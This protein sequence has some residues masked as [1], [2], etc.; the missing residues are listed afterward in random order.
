[1]NNDENPLLKEWTTAYGIPPFSDIEAPQFRQAFDEALKQDRTD[2]DRIAE[3]TD[4]PTFENTIDRLQLSGQALTKVASVFFNLTS[5]DTNPALQEIEREI[6]PRLASHRTKTYLNA[7]LFARIEKLR[8]KRDQLSLTDEQLK[9]LERIHTD[10]VRAGAKL[11]AAERE[12]MSE[13]EERLAQLS[14][15]F[16]QNVLAEEAG[17]ELRLKNDD[18]LAGLPDFLRNAAAQTA[19]ERGYDNEFV[20]TLS[21]SSIEPF[22]TFSERR[23]LREAAYQAWKGRGAAGGET[24][25]RELIDEIIE[26]RTEKANLLGFANFADY[27]LSDQMAKTPKAVHKLLNDVWAPARDRAA[28]EAEMLAAAAQNEGNNA[29]LAPWDWWHY[30]EK[31]RREKH[32]VDETEVKPYL[33]LANVRNAA[34]YVA[35]RLFGLKFKPVADVTLHHPDALAFDV[36]DQNGNHVGLFVGDYYA[37]PSKRGGAWMSAFRSQ[38]KLGE[39]IRPIIINVMNFVKAGPGE[40]DLLT[41]DDARTLF[42]E[43]GHALHGL[44][45]NVTYPRVACTNVPSDFV[46]LPSQLYEHWFLQPEILQ[47]FAVHYKTGKPMPE[48]LIQRILDARNFNQGFALVEFLAS[49]I[50]DMDL[51]ASAEGQSVNATEVEQKTLKRIDMPSAIE[52]RHKAT[53]FAHL[54]Q[55]SG[56]AAGYYSYLWSEVL[57]ADAFEAFEETGNVFDGATAKRLAENIYTVGGSRDVGETYRAFRGRDARVEALLEKRGLA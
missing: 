54:F 37:R 32:N 40:A 7:P 51:H 13:I 47:R 41:L 35:E 43:F 3:Q 27:R 53:H 52:P 16:G 24:D 45:S 15:T 14:T 2:I 28:S 23:D 39:D 48:D 50:T 31:V 18:D 21:R 29:P 42:H 11:S 1:M 9:V 4:A 57:D 22:L 33:Q 38:R 6:T 12:R 5:T 34:F 20:V 36:K 10:F 46:E 26:L 49:A 8:S 30:A 44:M 25:N 17:Y 56:Y 19:R 55:G